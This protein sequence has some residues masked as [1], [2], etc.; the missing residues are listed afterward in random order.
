M[1]YE[2]LKVYDTHPKL[3]QLE[4]YIE[5]LTRRH[6]ALA[7]QLRSGRSPLHHSLF[8]TGAINSPTCPI[9]EEE[10][11]TLTRYLFRCPAYA[12][13]RA[14]LYYECGSQGS[15]ITELMNNPRLRRSLFN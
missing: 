4:R 11:E 9:C 1:R 8:Q 10:D 7:F 12:R 14:R 15:S 3:K 2:K 6:A 13:S 5:G